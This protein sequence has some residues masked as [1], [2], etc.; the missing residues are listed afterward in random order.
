MLGIDRRVNFKVLQNLNIFN[1][2]LNQGRKIS[3]FLINAKFVK[4]LHHI[5]I[6]TP[7]ILQ[8]NGTSDLGNLPRIIHL[9]FFKKI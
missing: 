9:K 6:L 5:S 7:T 4:N 1:K 2:I 3:I 8:I